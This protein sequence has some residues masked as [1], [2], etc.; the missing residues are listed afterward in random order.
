MICEKKLYRV[1]DDLGFRES[2][3]GTEM[4]RQA[5]RIVDAN[6]SAMM[7]KDVY[8]AIAGGMNISR[9]ER[10]MRAA[11]AAA[12]RSPGWSDGWAELG[13]WGYPTVSEMIRRL[14]RAAQPDPEPRKSIR[15]M[16]AERYPEMCK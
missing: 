3:S 4:I 14:A 6:R 9:V 11:I 16:I 2:N 7:C 12:Q 10:A 15:A 5:V 13:G 1:M 8:P